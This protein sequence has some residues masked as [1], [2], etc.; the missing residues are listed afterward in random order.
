MVPLT[1]SCELLSIPDIEGFALRTPTCTIEGQTRF[2]VC[3]HGCD[4][5]CS[6][7]SAGVPNVFT[8]VF[9]DVP[10]LLEVIRATAESVHLQ[11]LG[12]AQWASAVLEDLYTSAHDDTRLFDHVC[13]IDV[14]RGNVSIVRFQRLPLKDATLCGSIRIDCVRSRSP[15]ASAEVLHGEPCSSPSKL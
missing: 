10:S 14:L 4:P 13:S 11:R 6:F 7:S 1:R 9:S 3:R 12:V 5:H 8:A 2:D 15:H